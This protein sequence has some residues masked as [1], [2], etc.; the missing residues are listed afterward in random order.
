[1][2]KV[3]PEEDG[4]LERGFLAAGATLLSCILVLLIAALVYIKRK[5]DFLLLNLFNIFI[6]FSDTLCVKIIKATVVVM[7]SDSL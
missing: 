4:G 3:V 1:M 6:L 5:V 2:L 7:F